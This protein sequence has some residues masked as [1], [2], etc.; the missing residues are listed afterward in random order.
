MQCKD[1]PNIPILEFIH[2][3]N[4]KCCVAFGRETSE[5]SVFHAMPDGTPLNLGLAK[6]RQLLKRGLVQGCG[7]GCRGDFT[8]TP[9]GIAYLNELDRIN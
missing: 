9:K 8:I 4:G 3:F 2:S 7:C 1:I 6:M 5:M